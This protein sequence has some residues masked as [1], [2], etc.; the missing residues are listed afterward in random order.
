MGEA[1]SEADR[2]FG[3]APV[4]QAAGP[5][6]TVRKLWARLLCRAHSGAAGHRAGGQLSPRAVRAART[7]ILCLSGGK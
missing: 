4:W 7:G 1:L 3:V 5:L 6:C 2:A